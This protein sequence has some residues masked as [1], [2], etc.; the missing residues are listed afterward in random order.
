MAKQTITV[1]IPW[2]TILLALGLLAAF[3]AAL[4]AI[5]SI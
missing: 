4:F 3:I 2:T 1:R 5:A